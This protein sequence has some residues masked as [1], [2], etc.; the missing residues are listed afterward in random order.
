MPEDAE[1][2]GDFG[3]S[4]GFVVEEFLKKTGHEFQSI[5]GYDHSEALIELAVAKDIPDA[6][7][8][9]MDLN[10]VHSFESATFDIVT[11]FETLEHVGNATN[12]IANLVAATKPGGILLVSVPNEVKLAGIMKYLGRMAIRPGAYGSFFENQSR[13]TYLWR[14]VSDNPISD[15]RNPDQPGY[16]PHLGFDYRQI[17]QAMD[18]RYLKTGKLTLLEKHFTKMKMNV[19]YVFRKAASAPLNT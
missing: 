11:C 2:W 7:F 5:T 10:I 4:N 1:T 6:T 9:A 3:C 18:T 17:E 8:R 15:F 13:I 16:G 14:L 12:A 19:T